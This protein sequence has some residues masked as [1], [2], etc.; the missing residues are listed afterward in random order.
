VLKKLIENKDFVPQLNKGRM[1][2]RSL[3]PAENEVMNRIG[4]SRADD[5][6]WLDEIS[7]SPD[8]WEKNIRYWHR[9]ASPPDEA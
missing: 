4:W 9:L 2:F 8:A 3:S 7:G 1:W 6:H 5:V